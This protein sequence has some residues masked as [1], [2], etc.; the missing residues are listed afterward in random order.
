MR[1][2]YG[3]CEYW[4]RTGTLKDGTIRP[5]GIELNYLAVSLHDLFR[6]MV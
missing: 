1:L 2:T 3:G 4:D 6:R 5:A